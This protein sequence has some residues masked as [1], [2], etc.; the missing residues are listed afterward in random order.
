M[1]TYNE[2]QMRAIRAG[3]GYHLVLA[4]PG[5][6]KTDILAERIACARERGTDFADMLCLT[7]TNRA[8]RGMRTRVMERVGEDSRE[9]FIGNLHRFCSHFLFNNALVPQHTSIIDEEDMTDILLEDGGTFF[10]NLQGQ[11]D[12]GRLKAVDE[13]DSYISQR[14]MG[15]PQE[16]ISVSTAVYERYYRM[17]LQAGLKSEAVTGDG[18]AETLVRYTLRYREYKR[19]RQMLGF[20][21]ILIYAYEHL[22]RDA[23][24]T[25]HRY[26]WVQVDEVQDLN[27][28]Q[29]A[30]IDELTDT[31]GGFSVMYLGDEQQAIFSFMGSK[32]GQLDCLRERCRGNV[33]NLGT[34]YR[35]PSYLLDVFNTFAERELAVDP[36]LL[37]RPVHEDVC[38][39]FDL[40]L[41]ANDTSEDETNR[42]ARMINHYLHYEGERVAVLVPTNMM[43]D[44]VSRKLHEQ[45]IAHFKISGTDMFRTKDY[46]IL[47][48][49]LTVSVNEFASM[50]WVRLLYGIGFV[51]TSGRARALV[52]CLKDLMMTPADLLAEQSYV[53]RFLDAY[54]RREFVFFD[55]ETTGLNML[56]DDIVQIAAFK[57]RAGERV[58]GSDFN[59]FLHTDREIPSHLGELVNPLVEAYAENPHVGRREGLERF[60]RYIG[61]CPVLGHNV[62]FDY[63]ILQSN[64][65]RAIGRSVTLDVYDSL[66]LIRCV[67]PRLR[68]YKLAFLLDEL[69]LEGQNSHLADE[70]IAATKAVVDYCVRRAQGIAEAQRCFT[71]SVK[72]RNIVERMKVL[73]ILFADLQEVLH[74]PVE[75]SGQR[76][77]TVMTSL[78]RR[79]TA[80]GYIHMAEPE[81]FELFLRYIDSEWCGDGSRETLCDQ[82]SAHVNDMTTGI[83]EADL[84]DC[85]AS[86]DGRVFIMTVYKGKGLEFENV[87][88]LG[89]ND[90]TYPFYQ[91]N[92]VLGAPWGHTAEELHEAEQM[93]LEDA[94]KFY[95]ALSRARKRLCISYSFRNSYGIRTCLT[96]FMDCIEPYFYTGR[97]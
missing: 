39:R 81:K 87:I 36:S 1:K 92:K 40:I 71:D 21:D 30:I 7:F 46:K 75:E 2:D 37:P 78:A 48:S 82:I 90:G 53:S 96:P 43:A 38:D 89:A 73:R 77:S 97:Q 49:L 72:V 80:L 12:R 24:R 11:P 33:M 14:G 68:R 63:R 26:P 84:L 34:N 95:V 44:R 52:G 47:S 93:R 94:R 15:H 28:L 86:Y 22:R 91:V 69:N 61:D 4:P 9:V 23:E 58:P 85:G 45:D 60:L 64:V 66:H 16:V 6:G 67:E 56:E 25:F 29:L 70:D 74:R 76:L 8:A 50:A 55:T 13:L 3:E 42:V 27:A 20:S 51:R 5:C 59:L 54:A 31:R 35:S 62:G 41:T 19:N 88:V 79:L 57:V 10:L 83:S 18:E 17:A 65:E 32:L